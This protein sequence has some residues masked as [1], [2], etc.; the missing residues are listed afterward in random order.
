MPWAYITDFKCNITIWNVVSESIIQ[1]FFY[2]IGC[3]KGTADSE[4]VHCVR[5]FAARINDFNGVGMSRRTEPRSGLEVGRRR[6]L[7]FSSRS[8]SRLGSSTGLTFGRQNGLRAGS[9]STLMF[10]LRVGN[11]S[12][13]GIFIA[14]SNY[15]IALFSR[16]LKQKKKIICN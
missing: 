10:G 16:C 9:R 15:I 2:I 1:L 14:N 4:L 3:L 13:L 12:S 11:S 6:S 5:C 7:T 8:V